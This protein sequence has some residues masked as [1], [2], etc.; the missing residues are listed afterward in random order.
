MK[1]D[2]K[3]LSLEELSAQIKDLGL[4]KFRAVKS[5]N[6]FINTAFP[7]LMK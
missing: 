5:L 7:P 1:K 3:S 6:G 2:I 4:P